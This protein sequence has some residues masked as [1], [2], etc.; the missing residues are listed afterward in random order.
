MS[1][2]TAWLFCSALA[3]SSGCA[4]SS[5]QQRDKVEQARLALEREANRLVVVWEEAGPAE[6]ATMEEPLERVLAES[7]SDPRV[8]E[9]RLLLASH[10]LEQRR[11]KDADRI[12][13]PLLKGPDGPARD[14]A[15]I[16]KAEGLT[17][18][19][20]GEEALELL[21]PLSGKL[22]GESARSRHEKAL[23]LAA[24]EARR[25]RLT[26]LTMVDWLAEVRL[27]QDDAL[28]FIDVS[29]ERGPILAQKRL[30]LEWSS[31]E[32]DGEKK[33]ASDAIGRLIVMRLART[34]LETKDARL[35][36]DLF[37]SGPTWLRTSEYGD[38]LANLAALAV[39]EVSSLGKRIGIVLGGRG[40]RESRH[41]ID[42]ARGITEELR[43]GVELLTEDF[44]ELLPQALAALTGQGAAV[45]VT[46]LTPEAAAE[47]R[48]FAELR[49][50]PTILLA[51]PRPLS[52]PAA[53][54]Y[55]FV[56]GSSPDE[57]ERVLRAALA[58][59]GITE[60]LVLGQGDE[61]CIEQTES[62]GT[63]TFPWRTWQGRVFGL[64]VLGDEACAAELQR[65]ASGLKAPPRI[66]LGLEAARAK[67]SRALS[68][69]AGTYPILRDDAAATLSAGSSFFESLGADAARLISTALERVQ[70]PG[71]S[72]AERAKYAEQVRSELSRVETPL[73]TTSARGFAG[74]N[75]IQRKLE[76]QR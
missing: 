54:A 40:K 62:A 18:E 36:R 61:T 50:V 33:K 57:E 35:A 24:I 8:A 68:L 28:R 47:A 73:D 15:Q 22:V 32:F 55:S 31:A 14:S 30:L 74:K 75:T 52:P 59:D 3:L 11:R 7:G 5:K 71:Q 58:E 65:E 20:R 49:R 21:L 51:A 41:S 48:D 72:D 44:R 45:L 39:D 19:G 25:W 17:L 70:L 26:I 60:V 76:V 64:I 37:R 4:S 29:R 2:R 27:S 56:L 43:E 53:T 67:T 9:L 13:A 63:L 42:V 10:Y 23:V 12:I 69:R 46:G 1:R 34:A 38:A 66:A 6:R 16:L